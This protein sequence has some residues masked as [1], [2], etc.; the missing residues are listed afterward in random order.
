MGYPTTFHGFASPSHKNWTDFRL[1]AFRP[2]PF[3]S[4]DVDIAIT[5]CGVCGSDVHMLSG[6]WK[7]PEY[8]LVVGHEVCGVVKRV[9]ADA[10]GDLK[11]GDIVGCGAQ[12]GSCGK[13]TSCE[14]GHEN[15]CKGG[16][17]DTYDGY[18]E[19][20]T[21]T[22]GGYSDFI[23][24]DGRFCFKIPEGLKP[25]EAAPMLC[26]GL[27]VFAPLVQ[28]GCGEGK[29]V[30][31]AGVGG[32]GHYAV[33]FARALGAE[34]WALSHSPNKENDCIKVSWRSW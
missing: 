10:V 17:V 21:R 26:G 1:H 33:Q 13:C 22:Q 6:G 19:D 31:I 5:H 4:T 24:V 34:V 32:L 25:E 3:T 9:G 15:Y 2:K 8:P 23:R 12:I 20:G 16:F 28:N 29:R 18:W 11:V 30:G 7:I 14:G 27:T